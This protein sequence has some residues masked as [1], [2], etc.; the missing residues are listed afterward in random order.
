MAVG[1]APALRRRATMEALP[2]VMMEV[3][4]GVLFPLPAEVVLSTTTRSFSLD[5]RSLIMDSAGVPRW[6]AR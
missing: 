3:W 2:C 6:Q 4:R 1:S 5:R